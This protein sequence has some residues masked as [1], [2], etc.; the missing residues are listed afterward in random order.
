DRYATRWGHWRDLTAFRA[1]SALLGKEVRISAGH[2]SNTSVRPGP[3]HLPQT[4]RWS[5]ASV[6]AT[7]AEILEP[8]LVWV[9]NIPWRKQGRSEIREECPADEANMT[10]R[11]C[12]F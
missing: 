12:Q 5:S 10:V 6:S 7:C 2:S 9:A 11:T 1:A 8:V 3:P 4:R